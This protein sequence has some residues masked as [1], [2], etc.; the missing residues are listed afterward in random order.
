MVRKQKTEKEPSPTVVFKNKDLRTS[1]R[2]D[3]SEVPTLPNSTILG[4]KD[5]QD[6]N[7]SKS[8]AHNCL[9]R[10]LKAFLG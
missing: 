5:S 8:E 6:P 10:V 2:V 7:Y 1:N 4:T 3:L 9:D